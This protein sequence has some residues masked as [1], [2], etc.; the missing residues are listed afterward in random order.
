[1]NLQVI[2]VDCAYDQMIEQR[3]VDEIAEADVETLRQLR[4]TLR[5]INERLIKVYKEFVD[6]VDDDVYRQLIVRPICLADIE[7]RINN[8]EYLCVKDYLKDIDLLVS[9]CKVFN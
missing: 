5:S 7:S 6:P 4:M 8:Q 3:K 1:M 2:T 9:N